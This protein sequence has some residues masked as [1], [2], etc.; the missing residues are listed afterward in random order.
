MKSWRA[1][2]TKQP[3]QV[4]VPRSLAVYQEEVLG[5]ELH[6]FGDTSGKGTAAAVY[7][8]VRQAKG[9]TQGLVTAKARLAKK[10]LTIPRLELE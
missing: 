5:I 10:E 9:V 3:K 4:E 7:A 8:V 6:G 1:W 2:N